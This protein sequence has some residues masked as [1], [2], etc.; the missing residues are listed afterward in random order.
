MPKYLN[1]PETAAYHK[2]HA[3]FGIDLADAV[4]HSQRFRILTLQKENARH[5]VERDAV[6]WILR[7]GALERCGSVGIQARADR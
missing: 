7:D 4:E 1:T 6:A 3:I 5:L 2:S